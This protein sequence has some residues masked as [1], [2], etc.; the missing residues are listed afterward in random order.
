MASENIAVREAPGQRTISRDDIVAWTLPELTGLRKVLGPE[1]YRLLRG[2]VTNPL[3]VAGLI[4]V[5]TFIL[6]AAFAPVLAPPSAIQAD[7]YLIPRDGFGPEPKPPG[8][9]WT[10]NPPE[11]PGWYRALTGRDE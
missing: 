3:S 7:P 5:S 11:V 6:V 10:K 2:L 4:I 9:V 8:T 1:W